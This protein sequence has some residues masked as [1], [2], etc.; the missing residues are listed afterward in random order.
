[1]VNELESND[2]DYTKV[3]KSLEEKVDSPF[4]PENYFK[5]FKREGTKWVHYK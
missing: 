3:E 2:F 5:N 1:M 4:D